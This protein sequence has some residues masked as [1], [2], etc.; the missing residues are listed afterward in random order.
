MLLFEI[1]PQ[2]MFPLF[3]EEALRSYTDPR[4]GVL[5]NIDIF[6]AGERSK[7]HPSDFSLFKE[8]DG[9]P[10]SAD[11]L[12]FPYYLEL[13]E[14]FGKVH[15]L[16]SILKAFCEAVP[17]KLVVVQWNH[18]VDFAV[19][20]PATDDPFSLSNIKN[21][22]VLNFNTSKKNSN[23]IV[24]PF[25]TIDTD[26]VKEEKKYKYGFLGSINHPV[27]R[28]LV[29]AFKDDPGFITGA[30]LEHQEFRKLVSSCRFSF[31]PRGVG[32]S[33]WRFFECMHLNTI[34]VL[35]ADDV[36]L[37]YP[38]LDYSK[39]CVSIPESLAHDKVYIDMYLDKI[40]QKAMLRNL[41]YARYLFTLKGVQEEVYRCLSNH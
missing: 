9:P 15:L 37:P 39:F 1:L 30:N 32:L 18:D 28:D 10:L 12:V 4:P 17:D 36:E 14:F 41:M 26:P 31:C 27:R 13:F 35:F 5:E 16:P 3:D 25:W 19:R 23:D 29:D 2:A 7:G 22:R 38:D 40:N 33:S 6:K 11:I 34:P 24:L 20:F 21:L 8:S